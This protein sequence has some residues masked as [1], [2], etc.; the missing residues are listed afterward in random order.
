MEENTFQTEQRPKPVVLMI[1]DGFGIAPDS[2]GNAVTRAN[3]P[4]LKDLIAK[5]PAMTL[6]AAGEEVGLS[7]G[8]MGN[9]E[10]GHLSIG[11]GRVYYQT[12]P[13]IDRDIEQGDF[14]ENK[15]FMDAV[16]HVKQHKSALHLVGLVS[17]GRIHA[18]DTHCH[19]LLTLAKQQALEKV[20]VHGFTDGRDTSFNAGVD[21]V[22]NL[23]NK[24]KELGVGKLASLSGRFYA[25]DRDNRW[26][27]VSLAYN[28][29]VLGQGPTAD[30]PIKALKDSYAKKVYDEEFLPTVMNDGGAPVGR[31]QDNDAIIFF[32][33]RSDRMR[34]MTK[35]FVVPEFKDFER[36][37]LKNIYPVTMTAYEDGLPVEVAYPDQP[38]DKSLG[39]VVSEA[40]LAQLHIAETE[41][42]AHVTFFVNGRVETPFPGEERVIIPSPR[43]SSY[44]QQPEMSLLKVTAR[45]LKEIESGKYDLIVTNFA[46]PDMVAHTGNL[47]ATIKAHEVVDEQVGKVVDAALAK[48]GAVVILA[49]HGNSEELLN[50]RTGEIDKEH[51]TNA[52]PL[53]II[54]RQLAGQPSI[55]GEVPEGDLSLMPPVGML[56]DV[57]PTVLHLM[58]LPQPP[59]MTGQPLC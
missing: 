49:D 40:R 3:M 36:V 53:L 23:L 7:W 56:A 21:F 19:T 20:F 6:R 50:V 34:Q 4:R 10:V 1:L 45:I 8:E 16:N 52:V 42:Y 38:I 26:E 22:G 32:N 24:M 30:D 11:A 2:P 43:V 28:A 12:L 59:E 27:R 44:D 31:I 37:A 9:S 35:A 51:S 33:Y 13:K 29:M 41:K 14:F 48:G 17:P 57:A 47:A 15:A 39:Q 55:A 58:G 46:N 5:Y 18:M 25:M 54:S